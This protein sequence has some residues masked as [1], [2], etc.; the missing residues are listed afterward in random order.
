M[1]AQREFNI[2][3]FCRVLL[4]R[5][6]MENGYHLYDFKGEQLREEPVEK[7]KQ[8]VWRPRPPSLLSKEEQK[9][10]R[11]NLREYSKV[12]DQ[13]DADRGAS[14]DLAVVEH[15]RRLLD[16]WLSWREQVEEDVKAE[17]REKGLPEDPLEGLVKRT[18]DGEDQIIEEIVEEIVEENEEVIP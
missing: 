13:E 16:E 14:A 18:E 3:N 7:F 8:W 10:I 5:F 17:R 12:F 2:I 4:M 6:Q 15:R 9:Q 11:K 1:E